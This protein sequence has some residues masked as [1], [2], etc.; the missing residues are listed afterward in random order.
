MSHRDSGTLKE[1]MDRELAYKS[2]SLTFLTVFS[3]KAQALIEAAAQRRQVA[4][5]RELSRSSYNFT[6]RVVVKPCNEYGEFPGFPCKDTLQGGR[7]LANIST[8]STTW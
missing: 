4:R 3:D 7:M 8:R 1:K 5:D 6:H 2:G